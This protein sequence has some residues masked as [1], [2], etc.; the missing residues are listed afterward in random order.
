[1]RTGQQPVEMTSL[2]MRLSWEASNP[3]HRV[4]MGLRG[5]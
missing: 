5:F 1:M 4:V 2:E 3:S